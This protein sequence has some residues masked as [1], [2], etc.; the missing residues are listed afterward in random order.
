MLCQT[1]LPTFFNVIINF[2]SQWKFDLK[3]NKHKAY[4]HKRSNLFFF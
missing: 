1:D 3:W 4:Q 2:D